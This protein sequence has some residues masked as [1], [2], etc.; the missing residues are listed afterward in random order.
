VRQ[1]VGL[2][3]AGA[4]LAACAEPSVAPN[5]GLAKAPGSQLRLTSTVNE[6]GSVMSMEGDDGYT[7]TLDMNAQH[8][9]RSD[10]LTLLI[11]VEQTMQAANAFVSVIQA[12]V[13]ANHFGSSGSGEP[14]CGADTACVIE[15]NGI[16]GPLL[17]D[18]TS[19][20]GEISPPFAATPFD[21]SSGR[22]FSTM[23]SAEYGLPTSFSSGDPC[24]D[25]LQ[26]VVPQVDAYRN[27]RSV[28]LM[29]VFTSVFGVGAMGQLTKSLPAGL[30]GAGTALYYWVADQVYARTALGVMAWYWNT[31]DCTNKVPRWY[32]GGTGGRGVLVCER[33]VWSIS[34]DGGNTSKMVEVEV[35]WIQQ[36]Y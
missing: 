16:G 15:P 22:G 10:G 3:L 7:Y 8:I 31:Y 2:A 5:A 24:S 13:V 26:A 29:S 17:L 1:L 35:C 12:D 6:D 23:I 36:V 20:D 4:C 33:D 19:L 11:D 14:R 30:A 25:I 32:M 9:R 27:K 28:G 18:A 21:P 34:F